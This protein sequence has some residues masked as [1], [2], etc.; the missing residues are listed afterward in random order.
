MVEGF[1]LGIAGVIGLHEEEQALLAEHIA[2][3]RIDGA[4]FFGAAHR[5]LLQLAESTDVKVVI[6]RLSR[7]STIDATGALALGDVIDKLRRHHVQVL[8][9][10]VRDEHLRALDALGVLTGL[11]DEGRVLAATPEAISY[12]RKH[13]QTTGVLPEPAP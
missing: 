1:T 3:Y 11:R 13:L 8:V 5:F 10:G 2:A 9:S 4:L 6:L 7:V 12:A